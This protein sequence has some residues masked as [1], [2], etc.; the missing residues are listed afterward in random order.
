M[1]RAFVAQSTAATAALSPPVTIASTECGGRPSASTASPVFSQ[2]TTSDT[3]GT[4]ESA[5]WIASAGELPAPWSSSSA[6]RRSAPSPSASRPGEAGSR[7]V[8]E[9]HPATGVAMWS[10]AVAAAGSWPA[11]SCSACTTMAS[12]PSVVFTA[13]VRVTQRLEGCVVT[14]A[15]D[16]AG[17]VAPAATV[18]TSRTR[19]FCAPRRLVPVSA[20]VC[21]S[22]WPVAASRSKAA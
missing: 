9:T 22:A 13:S 3:S 10:M 18:S 14:L 2:T 5:A 20:A 4:R 16:P 6:R 17:T 15:T 19:P 7:L 21:V 12:C 8:T 11:V 1:P